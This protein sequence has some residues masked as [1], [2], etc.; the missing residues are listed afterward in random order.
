MTEIVVHG[1]AGRMGRRLI[2]LAPEQNCRLAAAID[3]IDSDYLGQDAGLLAGID[4]LG[5]AVT[6]NLPDDCQAC[7]LIDFSQ[8]DGTRSVLKWAQDH[9]MRVVIGTTGLTAK[10][11]TCIDEAAKKIAV[12]QA[13]NMSLGV[14]L[15]F[16]LAG[17]VAAILGDNFDIE[18]SE[19]HHRFKRDAP[20]GTAMGIAEAI[21]K[22]TGKTIEDTLVY[23]RHDRQTERQRGE[24]G[25]HALRSGSVVGRHTASF[26]SLGE[27][28]QLTHI[29]N[30]RDIF[31][32]GALR[33]ACWLADKQPGRY[34]MADVLGI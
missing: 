8:P 33:A 22:A 21:C 15:L 18:I 29:A 1:A 14:N 28:I 26:A 3:H 23:D 25:M 16:S 32:E 9:G 19:T 12:L 20:S 6:S 5:I 11:Q 2:A 24:I 31:A 30:N 27:E 13:P 34:T 7:V 17:K 10:D 4:K